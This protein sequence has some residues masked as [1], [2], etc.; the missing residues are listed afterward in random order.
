MGFFRDDQL[1]W[2]GVST[3]INFLKVMIHGQVNNL[4]GVNTHTDTLNITVVFF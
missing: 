4:A 3:I 1:N 2:G